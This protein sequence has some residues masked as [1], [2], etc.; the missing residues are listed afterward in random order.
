MPR[1]FKIVPKPRK[2]QIS[3]MRDKVNVKIME[4]ESA[5]RSTYSHSD[6][7]FRLGEQQMALQ[8]IL[9]EVLK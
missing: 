4:I 2:T 1:Q 5:K 7:A 6:A 3:V 8:W 9:R